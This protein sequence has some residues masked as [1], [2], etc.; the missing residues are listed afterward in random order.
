MDQEDTRCA[1]MLMSIV[2]ALM[3]VSVFVSVPHERRI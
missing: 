3:H 1:S 2:Q